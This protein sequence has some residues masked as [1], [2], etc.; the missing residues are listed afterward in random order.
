MPTDFS[1]PLINPRNP[2][3]RQ[4]IANLIRHSKA[5]VM[6]SPLALL[7]QLCDS[8][9]LACSHRQSTLDKGCSIE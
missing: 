7:D 5:L 2:H 9:R 8:Q 4:A 1:I 6:S 3:S